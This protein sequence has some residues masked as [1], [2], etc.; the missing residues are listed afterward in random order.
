MAVVGLALSC[1]VVPPCDHTNPVSSSPV[2]PSLLLT[3]HTLTLFFQKS[4]EAALGPG[5]N[6]S[7]AKLLSVQSVRPLFGS[8]GV[9]ALMALMVP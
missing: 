6:Q 5:G 7:M 3:C 4:W 8:N 2:G 9:S 1:A